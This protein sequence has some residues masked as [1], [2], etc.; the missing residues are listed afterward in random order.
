M[1]KSR[2]LPHEWYDTPN[3]HLCTIADFIQLCRDEGLHVLDTV[4]MPGQSLV[5]CLLIAMGFCNLGAERVMVRLC[6]VTKQR[7]KKT[8]ECS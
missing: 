1:P 2:I 4:C 5:D 6:G 3:I 8:A 7:H